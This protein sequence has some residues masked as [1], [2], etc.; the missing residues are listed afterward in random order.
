MS[1]PFFGTLQRWIFSGELQDPFQE[2]FVQLN[3]EGKRTHGRL[4]PYHAT[5]DMGFEGGLTSGDGSVEAHAVWEKKYIFVKKMVPGF[6]SEEFGKK[7]RRRR[8]W[9]RL[10]ADLFH[11][12]QLELHPIQLSRQRLDRDAGQVGQCRARSAYPLYHLSRG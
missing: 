12:A 3:P 9:S 1:K 5:G 8:Q 10:M 4:S 2:F 11:R 6:V 7:V